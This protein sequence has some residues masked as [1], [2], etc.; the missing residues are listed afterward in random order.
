MIDSTDTPDRMEESCVELDH[1]LE[2]VKLQGV[3]LLVFANKQD[4]MSALST[5][6]ISD[7]LNL[8]NITGRPWIIQPCSAKD[9][10]GLKEGVEWIVDLVSS[11]TST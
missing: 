9:G 2:E 1:L 4:L 11:S 8:K 5:D 6:E 10:E 7:L 3:P